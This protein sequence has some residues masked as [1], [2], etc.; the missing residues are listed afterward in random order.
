M[1][2]LLVED[3]FTS[4]EIFQTYAIEDHPLSNMFT[5]DH[6]KIIT[7]ICAD[8]NGIFLYDIPNVEIAIVLANMTNIHIG[9]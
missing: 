4:S 2:I 6:P 8:M 1:A 3:T 9:M 5:G 7:R